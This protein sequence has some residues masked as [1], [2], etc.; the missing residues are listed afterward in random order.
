[1]EIMI[2]CGKPIDPR[3]MC[4]EQGEGCLVIKYHIR[5]LHQHKLQSVSRHALTDQARDPLASPAEKLPI[6]LGI[7]SRM[8]MGHGSSVS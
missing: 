2:E 8:I 5:A 3:H 1:M 4:V 7:H 6:G